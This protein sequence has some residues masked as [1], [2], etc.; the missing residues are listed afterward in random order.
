LTNTSR[1]AEKC[2]SYDDANRLAKIL[3][4][5]EALDN[6]QL[7]KFIKAYAANSQLSGSYGFNGEQP[8]TY[9]HGLAKHIS[10]LTGRT[11]KSNATGRIREI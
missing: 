6:A 11:F 9:G 2:D 5:I 3:P 7:K 8:S 4:A 10:R 1:P